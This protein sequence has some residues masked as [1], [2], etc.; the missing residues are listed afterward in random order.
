MSRNDF[1]RALEASG[2]RVEGWER[3][4][5]LDRFQR[6]DHGEVEKPPA[7]ILFEL[8]PNYETTWTIYIHITLTG[9]SIAE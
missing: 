5:L 7:Q 6:G 3:E 9:A 4:A 8:L 1:S 2:I